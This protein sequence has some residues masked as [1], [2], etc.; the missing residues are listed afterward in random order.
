MVCMQQC[1]GGAELA[2][3]GQEG[4][5]A[6]G[7][8]S[9]PPSGAAAGSCSLQGACSCCQQES[10]IAD[11]QVA[12]TD[13]G[14]NPSPGSRGGQVGLHWI[15]K[16]EGCLCQLLLFVQLEALQQPQVALHLHCMMQHW[17]CAACGLMP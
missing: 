2:A 12:A 1:G 14:S 13:T 17:H 10:W 8:E 4:A 6:Q 3:T 11:W 15:S 16:F 7:L 5:H 9:T